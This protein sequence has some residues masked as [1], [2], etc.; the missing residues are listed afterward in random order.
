MQR[1]MQSQYHETGRPG[2]PST[3]EYPINLVALR[4]VRD[5]PT[6]K[7]WQQ[8]QHHV[9][10]HSPDPIAA[11][12]THAEADLPNVPPVTD[13]V[14]LPT[15]AEPLKRVV[16]NN[17]S[18]KAHLVVRMGWRFTI[19]FQNDVGESHNAFTDWPAPKKA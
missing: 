2:A 1:V 10:T 11:E 19:P 4:F 9:E 13:S 12:A 3:L 6:I 7:G 5:A 14:S 17:A 18:G 15:P 8:G 16:R